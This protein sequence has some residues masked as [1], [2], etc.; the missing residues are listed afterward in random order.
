MFLPIMQL[1]G[2]AAAAGPFVAGPSAAVG[3]LFGVR[4]PF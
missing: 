4:R 1:K 3:P 2:S